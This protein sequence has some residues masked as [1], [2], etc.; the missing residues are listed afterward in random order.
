MVMLATL[1]FLFCGTTAKAQ[2]LAVGTNA[3]EWYVTA[4]NA[5][6]VVVT[7]ERT[8][9]HFDGLYCNKPF[10]KDIRLASFSPEVRYWFIGRPFT[11]FFV[12]GV[13]G[14]NEYKYNRKDTEHNGYAYTAGLSAGYDFLLGKKLS[15]DL[16]IGAGVAR[17]RE[18]DGDNGFAPVPMKLGVSLIYV[19]E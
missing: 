14:F 9:L 5:Q 6:V 16:S 19:I 13:A 7:G 11:K 2:R 8:T 12:G 1:C 18:K 15:L 17:Y 10:G 3:L 4:P